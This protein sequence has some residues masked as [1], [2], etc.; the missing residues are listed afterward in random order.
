MKRALKYGVG[1]LL[2]L[3]V[4]AAALLAVSI[5]R[6]LKGPTPVACAPAPALA[7]APFSSPR[8]LSGPSTPGIR[9]YDVE[10][11]AAALADGTLAV[12]FNTRD[13]FWKR[14]SGLAVATVHPDGRSE[15]SSLPTARAEAFDAWMTKDAS[16]R[17]QLVWLAHDG[18]RPE[19][20][21]SVSW[22][23]SADGRTWTRP[24]RTAHGAADCPQNEPG[25]LDKPMVLATRDALVVFYYSEPAGGL[26]AV[27]LPAGAERAGPS[28]AVPGGAYG[29]A[30]A[31]PSGSLHVVT[32]DS[33][34]NATRDE[35]WGSPKFRVV[36]SRSDDGGASFLPA[37]VVS[38]AGESIPFYFSNAQVEVDEARG[39]LYVAYPAGPAR[40]PWGIRLAT[41]RDGGKTWV[42]R[43]VT[44]DSPCATRMTPQTALDPET[45]T[46]HL[47]WLDNRDG[48]GAL[49]YAACEPGGEKCGPNLRVSE[50]PF[51]SFTFERNLAGWLG[52][53]GALHF[54]PAQR[55]LHAL[56][57]QPVA[58]GGGVASRLFHA[59][60][61]LAAPPR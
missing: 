37:T 57:S 51:E 45:G 34:E 12:V 6:S 56:W 3:V 29:S 30:R 36:Y 39:L 52:E 41:S 33:A 19:R 20:N 54:D 40:G 21:M 44:D 48:R 28:V 15:V 49:A 10:P 1:G 26:R 8:Q 31:A 47:T 55:A 5:F 58:E 14:T 50:A 11:T 42:Y 35:R 60:L 16:G 24:A 27:R 43:S 61:A 46:V 25:C 13:P 32:V 23:D 7:R 2:L 9:A 17:L 53:Y 22:T 18:G 59:R 38:Q 4:L